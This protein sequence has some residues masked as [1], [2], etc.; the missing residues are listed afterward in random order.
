MATTQRRRG[1]PP[2]RPPHLWPDGKFRTWAYIDP[3]VR[4]QILRMLH[5]GESTDAVLTRFPLV[6]VGTLAA[7]KAQFPRRR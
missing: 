5:M 6:T 4:V 1:A 3:T 2:P 7:V